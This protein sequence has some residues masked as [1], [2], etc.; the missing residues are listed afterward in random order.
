MYLYNNTCY[1]ECYDGTYKDEFTRVCKSCPL[2]CS[3][4]T[5]LN[6]N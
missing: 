2:G 1:A 6:V 4:C 5:T 3:S